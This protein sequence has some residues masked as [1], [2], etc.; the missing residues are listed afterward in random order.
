M[1]YLIFA[2]KWRPMAFQD[3]VGQEHVTRTLENAISASRIAHAYLFS[4]PRGTGKTSTIVGK[5]GY[6]IERG[7]AAPQDVLLISF[8]RKALSRGQFGEPATVL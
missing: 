5:A 1:S 3:V 8:A 7:F 4:G 2:R 6:L